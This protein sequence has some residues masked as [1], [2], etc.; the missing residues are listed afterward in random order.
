MVE[1]GQLG[2]M[3][4]FFEADEEWSQGFTDDILFDME[5]DGHYY[6]A[7]FQDL[8]CSLVI[9]NK[10]IYAS[11]GYDH[12][13]ETWD[14]L[15]DCFTKLKEAGYVP[16]GMGNSGQWVANSCMFGALGDRGAGQSWYDDIMNGTGDGFLDKNM[17]LGVEKMAELSEMGFMNDNM[18]SIDQ[19]EV[20]PP[21]LEGQYASYIDGSWTFA[22]LIA[23]AGDDQSVVEKSGVAVLPPIEGGKGEYPA[24]PGGSAWGQAYNAN[25]TGAKKEA[26]RLF[27]K[28]ISDEQWCMD[29]AEKGDFG[30]MSVDYDY[31]QISPILGEYVTLKDSVIKTPQYDCHFDTSVID[32]MNTGLQELLLGE[33][34]AEE[35][36]SRVQEEYELTLE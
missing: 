11:V 6:G 26:A 14:E 28:Y 35:W 4:E 9:Y 12:F 18:N 30:G 34:T 27:I 31:S 2:T 7:P 24:T 25:L 29:L 20:M 17:L 36:G 32:T 10:D 8:C 22:T 13:P 16:L 23:T 5:Y 19:F 1:N 3:D 33:I 21:Y 15:I